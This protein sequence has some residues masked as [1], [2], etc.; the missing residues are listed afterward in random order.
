MHLQPAIMHSYS[1]VDYTY[2][3]NM[4]RFS[5]IDH[6]LVSEALFD[7]AITQMYVKHEIDNRSDHDPIF[8]HLSIN[9]D[10]FSITPRVFTSRLV[11][12]RASNE[13]KMSYQESLRTYTCPKS[14][15]QPKSYYV[16]IQYVATPNTMKS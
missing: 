1:L 6:F 14:L 3:F 10:R 11:W 9:F 12:Q 5:I 4:H 2:N 8:M 13:D 15:Y 7:E 16:I